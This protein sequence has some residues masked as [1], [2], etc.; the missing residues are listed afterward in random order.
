MNLSKIK[1]FRSSAGIA[2]FMV[3]VVIVRR[4]AKYDVEILRVLFNSSKFPRRYDPMK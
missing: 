4:A 3:G 1:A 2:L